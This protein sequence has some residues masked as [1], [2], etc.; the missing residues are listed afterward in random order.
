MKEN[1]ITMQSCY[2]CADNENN[3]GVNTCHQKRKLKK[4]ENIQEFGDN[5]KALRA[6]ASETVR[7]VD[8]HKLNRTLF[9]AMVFPELAKGVKF[10]APFQIPTYCFQ[11]KNSFTI[12]TNASGNAF[13]QINF[14]QFL[15]ASLFKTGIAGVGAAGANALGYFNT[16]GV[17][18]RNGTSNVANS[19]VFICN[20]PSLNGVTNISSVGTVMQ[21]VNVCQVNNGTFNSIKAGP[22]S[23][24][25]EYIGR[26]DISAGNVTCGLNYSSVAD[27]AGVSAGANGLYPD[28]NY[29]V[30]TAL[31]DSPFARTLPITD[32]MKAVFVPQ[33]YTLMNLKSPLDSTSTV[34]PQR[35]FFLILAGPP[36]QTVARISVTQNWEGTP[37]RSFADIISLSY[38]S[39][40]ADYDGKEIYD[41][42]IK[43]NL[44]ITKDESEFGVKKF[45]E[46][47]KIY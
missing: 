17:D 11:Q 32:P 34:M 45:F 40:P 39:F 21:G 30:L 3:H 26:L 9:E 38:N 10:P 8:Y 44:I 5:V 36:N 19:N 4:A 7:P 35:L 2:D 1:I 13:V 41:Y 16:T 25:Y 20:D 12:T 37:T 31:E 15:D 22:A 24:K 28:V 42:M 18:N 27:P 29:S 43:N 14:G 46:Q 33:D 47:Y 6:H 23:V